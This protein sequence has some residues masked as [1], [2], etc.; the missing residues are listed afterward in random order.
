[1]PVLCFTLPF[2]GLRVCRVPSHMFVQLA[3]QR[4]LPVMTMIEA[5]NM[6]GV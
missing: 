3:R 2:I 4:F 5:N 6:Q 1:V